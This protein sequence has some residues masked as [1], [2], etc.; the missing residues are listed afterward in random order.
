MVS[1]SR[2]TP[3]SA[4]TRPLIAAGPIER[5]LRPARSAGSI[6]PEA[7]AAGATGAAKAAVA[8]R[9]TERARL[10][11]RTRRRMIPPGGKVPRDEGRTT[12][13]AEGAGKLRLQIAQRL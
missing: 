5:A 13:L 2:S 9:E 6:A 10:R 12:P 7:G 8:R 4:A 11:L 3:A 1:G